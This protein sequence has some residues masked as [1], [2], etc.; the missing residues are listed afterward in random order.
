MVADLTMSGAADQTKSPRCAVL[1]A[2]LTPEEYA[3]CVAAADHYR[4]HPDALAAAVLR[5]VARD[6]LFDAF[7]GG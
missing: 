1:H 4:L 2:W 7:L 5:T 3:A 6:R